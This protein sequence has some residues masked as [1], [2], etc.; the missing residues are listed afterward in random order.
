MIVK[1]K[2]YIL[3][4]LYD[5][6]CAIGNW[7]CWYWTTL[8]VESCAIWSWVCWYWRNNLWIVKEKG[9]WHLLVKKV[10]FLLS[11]LSNFL[12]HIV[13]H[14][15]FIDATMILWLKSVV[16]FLVVIYDFL[17]VIY[18]HV[19]DVPCKDYEFSPKPHVKIYIIS[20]SSL[21]C[22]CF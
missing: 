18:D 17:V 4:T 21:I 13:F 16:Y 1:N 2:R 10:G 7:I 19:D 12:I 9:F 22:C 5:E 3:I 6:S 15:D 11:C 8:Y 14:I 20:W